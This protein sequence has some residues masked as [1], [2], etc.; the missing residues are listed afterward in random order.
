[1]GSA[2]NCGGDGNS[3]GKKM[4]IMATGGDVHTITATENKID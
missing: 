3:N 4:G 1:M 2:H